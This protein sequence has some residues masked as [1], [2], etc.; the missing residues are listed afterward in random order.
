MFTSRVVVVGVLTLLGILVAG[1]D[2]AATGERVIICPVSD[3]IDDGIS[4]FVERAVKEGQ[5]AKA[6]IFVI[7]TYGGRLDS[8]VEITGKI[9]G[10]QCRT[11]AYI[12]ERGAISAGALISY[13]C[14][15]IIM[16]PATNIGAATPVMM[17]P[18]GPLP[19]TEK[20]VS[21]MRARMR[22]L[23][24]AKDH[25][26]DIA[27]AMVDPDIELRARMENGKPVVYASNLT[28]AEEKS[29]TFGEAKDLIETIMRT[30]GGE[31]P[32]PIE[33]PKPPEEEAQKG[34]KT[35]AAKAYG[36]DEIIL[37]S[38]KLLTLTS[39]E[40]VKYGVIP[41]TA[42]TIDEVM[43]FYGLADLEKVELEMTWSEKLFR[44]L[45]SPMVAG[46]LLM[47]GVGGLYWEM[48]TPGFGFPGILGISC[49]ALFFGA[50]LIIGL[51]DW[52]DI[53]L[54]VTGIALILLEIFVFPGFG[55]PGAAGILCVL[56]GI[57]LSLTK[58][59]IPQ[60]T[61][62]FERLK[63][64]GISGGI[65]IISLLVFIYILW[66]VLPK[67]SVYGHVVL[68]TAEGVEHGFVVQTAADR[69]RAIG[70]KGTATSILRPAGRGRFGNQTY[71]VVSRGEFIEIGSPIVIVEV[72]G[73]RYVV[74]KL[75]E[76]V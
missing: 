39:Q 9:L 16:V 64:A 44:F 33:K 32:I 66:K 27:Q 31:V 63:N 4:V 56:V 35:A 6:I 30:I 74:D 76:K 52:I 58:V 40:A 17:S 48:K 7:D 51:A 5:G 43:S 2:F 14:D 73:N 54:V 20:E 21:F 61:W 55:L 68:Q 3:M 13:S 11:I 29:D 59:P 57:Y 12:R 1:N 8:A 70:L 47:L 42:N 71:D 75:E 69:E 22:T 37:A 26:P 72:E 23:A 25:N 60:Y 19:T 24:E 36:Q 67:T 65:A 10:A 46:I 49:L 53:L 62:E 45:T 15:D 50:H 34:D 18:E 41:T 28:D 38:G